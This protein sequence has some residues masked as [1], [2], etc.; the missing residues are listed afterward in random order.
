MLRKNLLDEP[1]QGKR[2]CTDLCFAAAGANPQPIP[3][4][5][6]ARPQII[7]RMLAAA[8]RGICEGDRGFTAF[9]AEFAASVVASWTPATSFA[10][11]PTLPNLE[12]VLPRR[13]GLACT[14]YCLPGVGSSCR[15][16][17][18]GISSLYIECPASI[19]RLGG[20]A[21]AFLQFWHAQASFPLAH[22]IF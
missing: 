14:M 20:R 21:I 17:Y 3:V 18:C 15:R 22:L 10:F 19:S 16:I 2:M 7:D 1:S 11:F 13:H 5:E 12:A 9:T 4:G 8:P 6:Q